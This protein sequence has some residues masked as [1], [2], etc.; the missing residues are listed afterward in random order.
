M[1][2]ERHKHR[3]QRYEKQLPVRRVQVDVKCV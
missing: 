2:L 3:F 1:Y